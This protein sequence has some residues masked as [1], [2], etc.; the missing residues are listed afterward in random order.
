M[1]VDLQRDHSGG[2]LVIRSDDGTVRLDLRRTDGG[3][4]LVIDSDDG[5]A[6]IDLQRTESGGFLTVDTDDGS[7]RFEVVRGDQG[8]QLLV[9]SDD[10][11]SLR[12][13]F[14][15][16]A[17]ALPRWVPQLDGMPDQPRRI[18]SLN[19]DQGT[20][21][22]V[23]WDQD[24]TAQAALDAFQAQLEDAGYDIR[25]ELRGN[26]TDYEEGSLWAKHPDSGRLV[27]VVAHET[28]E[29]TKLLVGYGE[30]IR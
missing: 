8:A 18:Y 19:A 13:S 24:I 3:G 26:D 16:A 7:V 23:A 2:S 21:G 28:Y 10:G 5:Q 20:L 22:A 4:S 6:R 12:L 30:E 11:Q 1:S 9:D 29:G 27:F 14:G 17:Q 15:E 25:A